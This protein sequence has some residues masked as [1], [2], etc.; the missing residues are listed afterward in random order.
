MSFAR[1]SL[2]LFHSFQP[3][4]GTMKIGM[5]IY[6]AMKSDVFQ[7]PSRNTGNPVI[8]VIMVDPIKPTHAA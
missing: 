5:P 8:N 2:D 3:M 1:T 7:L 4:I 6:D